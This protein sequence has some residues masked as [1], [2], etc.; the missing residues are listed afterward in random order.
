MGK[1]QMMK[2]KINEVMINGVDDED[3]TATGD[4]VI[5]MDVGSVSGDEKEEEGKEKEEEEEEEAMLTYLIS[6]SAVLSSQWDTG[7]H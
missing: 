3:A 6:H 7:I 2:R 5:S 4:G 1:K